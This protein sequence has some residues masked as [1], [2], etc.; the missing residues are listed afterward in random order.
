[1]HEI[2]P[3]AGIDA[4]EEGLVRR[5]AELCKADLVTKMVVEMTSLQGVMG[6]FYALR[7]GEPAP[8]AQAIF[9]HYLPRYLG[10][11]NPKTRLGLVVGLADRLDTLAGLFAAGL[12]PTGT[13]DPF[14]QRRA[15]LG[16]VQNLI[17]WDLDF[18]LRAG[19][20]LAARS[21]PIDATPESQSACLDFIIARLR[22]YLIDQGSRFDVV[23]AVLASQRRNPAGA[24]PAINQLSAWVARPDWQT[25][26]P[27][28]ARCVRILRS[29]N[30]AERFSV[31]PAAFVEPAER[32]LYAALQQAE[33]APRRSASVDD[34]LKA[35]T[36]M[37]PAVNR[38]FDD[39]LV[40]AE[41]PAVRA[42]R[43]GLLQRIASL[44][45][46]VA[47]MSALEGF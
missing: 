13:K 41:D 18:D 1:V 17:A 25:I 4:A 21:L 33:A 3:V 32:D 22:S 14:A 37:I 16:L 30:H 10:D 6:S 9:E 27:A 11:A 28:Y 43:L 36:P 46:G 26:L 15:A 23:D 20:E 42:N 2:S 12:A 7:S 45:E 44:A 35:F 34:F 19:L 5:S 47:D 31:D 39:V 29:V 24:F 38:F 8:V 40:M